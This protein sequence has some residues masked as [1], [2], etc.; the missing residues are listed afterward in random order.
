ML[1]GVVSLS[2]LPSRTQDADVLT[3]P[4]FSEEVL[5][6][7][8]K[9]AELTAELEVTR[10]DC[11]KLQANFNVLGLRR[12]DGELFPYPGDGRNAA[13]AEL[14]FKIADLETAKEQSRRNVADAR[15]VFEYQAS[16]NI[17]PAADAVSLKAIEHV[18]EAMRLVEMLSTVATEARKRGLTIR[19]HQ[20]ARAA[21]LARKL[22]DIR[23]T[24]APIPT[25]GVR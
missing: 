12:A 6:A 5:E 7:E 3:L 9:L 17:T 11:A 20:V 22:H 2:L 23:G 1:A 10:G 21:D 4:E 14:H 16:A 19:H 25:T 13:L 15:R 24:L 8:D 18:E